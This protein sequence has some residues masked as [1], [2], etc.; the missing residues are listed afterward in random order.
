MVQACLWKIACVYATLC[1]RVRHRL[2]FVRL[3]F[4]PNVQANRPITRPYLQIVRAEAKVGGLPPASMS[5]G[6]HV[7]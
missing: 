2:Y 3:L 7:R 1:D 6:Q 5:R 4:I